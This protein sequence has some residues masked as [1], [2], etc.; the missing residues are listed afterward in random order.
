[1]TKEQEQKAYINYL[2]DTLQNTKTYADN[3]SILLDRCMKSFTDAYIRDF[4]IVKDFINDNKIKEA[5]N[6]IDEIVNGLKE[7]NK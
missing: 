3:L 6:F 7:R 2:E 4:G 5:Q 1:M